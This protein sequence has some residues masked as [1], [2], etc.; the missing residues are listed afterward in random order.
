MGG[1]EGRRKLMIGVV[2]V[3]PEGMRVEETKRLF[4]VM[5]VDVM[6]YEEKS[7]WG[8]GG[9]DINARIGLGAED[10]PNS[11]GKRLLDL[12]RLEIL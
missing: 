4:E 2:Y 11:N 8:G 5:Q 6:K 7:F 9:G 10:R 1:V 12:V 3:N